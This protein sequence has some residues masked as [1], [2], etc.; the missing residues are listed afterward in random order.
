MQALIMHKVMVETQIRPLNLINISY[1]KFAC[2][3]RHACYVCVYCALYI[4]YV[5]NRRS[6]TKAPLFTSRYLHARERVHKHAQSREQVEMAPVA[7]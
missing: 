7:V 6:V 2:T 4:T 5:D 1:T 3:Y